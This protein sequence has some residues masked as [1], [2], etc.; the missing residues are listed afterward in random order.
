MSLLL[1][2]TS[3]SIPPR[4][5]SLTQEDI[6]TEMNAKKVCKEPSKASSRM[7]ENTV[8]RSGFLRLYKI[9]TGSLSIQIIYSFCWVS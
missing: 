4:A 9:G 2:I 6:T 1:L 5:R 7:K 8:A 3:L